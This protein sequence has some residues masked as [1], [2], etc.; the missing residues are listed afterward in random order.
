MN[1]SR[2]ALHVMW[3]RT[4]PLNQINRSQYQSEQTLV[5]FCFVNYNHMLMQSRYARV[6]VIYPV[7]TLPHYSFGNQGT[8]IYMKLGK[9]YH[10]LACEHSSSPASLVSSFP[11][12]EVTIRYLHYKQIVFSWPGLLIRA[13]NTELGCCTLMWSVCFLLLSLSLGEE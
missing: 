2:Y 6:Y 5:S 4:I 8:P 9:T 10:I 13:Q 11:L 3:I 7:S 1:K 12:V